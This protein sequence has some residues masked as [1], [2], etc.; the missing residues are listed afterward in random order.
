[1]SDDL[2]RMIEDTG[3]F[4]RPNRY[5]VDIDL[6]DELRE[7]YQEHVN[8]IGLTCNATAL[9][10]IFLDTKEIDTGNSWFR[11]HTSNMQNTDFRFY[12]GRNLIVRDMFLKW[13]QL[14]VH[15][16]SKLL[17]YE[18]DFVGQFRI[19]PM[20]RGEGGLEANMLQELILVKSYPENVGQITLGYEEGNQV[21]MLNVSVK[22]TTFSPK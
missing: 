7:E 11:P 15:H 10:G 16:D 14:A 5:R 21:A 22:Y 2:M 12:V 18:D 20:G 13:Q 8:T 3:G 6:P 4:F 1:M 19:Y 9:P 17:G